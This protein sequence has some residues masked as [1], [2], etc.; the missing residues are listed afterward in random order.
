MN[1]ILSPA[2]RRALKARAHPLKPT[3]MIGNDG[4]SA[5]VMQEIDSTLKAH[6]LIKIRVDMEDSD[7]R[8]DMLGM[9][10][11]N[12]GASAIDHIGKILVVY[13]ERPQSAKPSGQAPGRKNNG[14]RGSKPGGQNAQGQGQGQGQGTAGQGAGGQRKSG[15]KP[16]GAVWTKV[17]QQRPGKRR[18]GGGNRGPGNQGN[19]DGGGGSGNGGGSGSGSGSGEA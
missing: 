4:L 18:S 5:S 3:V 8:E 19:S 2:E 1:K 11:A 7:E 16:G 14:Q 13:R 10:C 17:R 12:T 15:K 6:E 9:I